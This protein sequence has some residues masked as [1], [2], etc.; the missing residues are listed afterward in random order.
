MPS[1][2]PRP[3]TYP[4]CGRL[5]HDGTGRC[6]QHP[7]PTWAKRPDVVKRITGRRL[8]R[9]RE[10]LFR[11]QPLCEM[12]LP[13]GVFTLATQRD[14]RIP[15]EEGGTDTTDNEQ[16]LCEECH[17]AKSLQERLRGRA[18]ASTP[19]GGSKPPRL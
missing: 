9:M 16:A 17:E 10:E 3:C 13:K 7:R 6:H 4:G 2:A 14:H 18:R 11:R 19:G 1:A 5:V 15:L 8:Q 12:C